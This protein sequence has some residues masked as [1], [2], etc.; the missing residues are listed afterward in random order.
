MP[1]RNFGFSG[2]QVEAPA[3][4]APVSILIACALAGAVLAIL[5][6]MMVPA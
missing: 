6:R 2:L 3:W 4:R 1:K 5:Y